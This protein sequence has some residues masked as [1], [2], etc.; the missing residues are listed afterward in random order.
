MG[1]TWRQRLAPLAVVGVCVA[2]V[3]TAGTSS[4]AIQFDQPAPA[5]AALLATGAAQPDDGVALDADSSGASQED[6]ATAQLVKERARLLAQVAKDVQRQQQQVA[7]AAQQAALDE[8]E[9]KAKVERDRVRELSTFLWP[10]AGGVSSGFGMRM[11]PILKVWRLHNG[12]DIGGACGQPIWAAQ[13]G[14]VIAIAPSGYNG[15]AGHNVR[16][17]HGDINGV[18]IE[19]AYLHMD[20][21]EVKVGQQVNKGDRI[22]TVGSTGLS[23]ACH[24]HLT[25]YKDGQATDPLKYLSK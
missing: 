5:D 15:G 12:A 18:R 13:S 7:L 11:H 24:L 3:V 10:T 16:I 1:L 25:L 4:A 14:T 17:D 8:A 23:T 9:Q 22:G 6:G 20:G 2:T 21:I 19:T